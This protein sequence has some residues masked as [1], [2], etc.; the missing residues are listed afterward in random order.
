MLNLL[1]WWINKD[2]RWDGAWRDEHL[3]QRKQLQIVIKII[4]FMNN[5]KIT[6]K[7]QE[8][9]EEEAL[10]LILRINTRDRFEGY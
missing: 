5:W 10:L 4:Y 9:F 2:L 7:K 6:L 8:N 3:F 1:V